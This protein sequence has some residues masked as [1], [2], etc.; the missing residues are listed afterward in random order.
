MKFNFFISHFDKNILWK[1]IGIFI[2]IYVQRGLL[3]YYQVAFNQIFLNYLVIL[4]RSDPTQERK[5]QWEWWRT[6]HLPRFQVPALFGSFFS[7]L[8]FHK[9]YH[10]Y[11]QLLPCGISLIL[12]L[13]WRTLVFRVCFRAELEPRLLLWLGLKVFVCEIRNWV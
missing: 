10:L 5:C 3:I 8:L 12:G 11:S 6:L 2:T 1:F 13:W 9:L 7:C 4:V